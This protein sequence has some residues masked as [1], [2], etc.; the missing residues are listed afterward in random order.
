MRDPNEHFQKKFLEDMENLL[1]YTGLS[2]RWL[3][4]ERGTLLYGNIEEDKVDEYGD[5]PFHWEYGVMLIGEDGLDIM[6]ISGYDEGTCE[7]NYA[8]G[9]YVPYSLNFNKSGFGV[10]LNGRELKDIEKGS[11]AAI[12]RDAFEGWLDSWYKYFYGE[13]A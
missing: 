11:D 7:V 10:Y 3:L 12:F 1:E 2:K 5:E 9:G 8:N 4:D 6:E 13:K